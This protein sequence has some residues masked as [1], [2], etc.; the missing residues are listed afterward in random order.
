M[1]LKTKF[2]REQ[3]KLR[4]A[5]LDYVDS[6]DAL[7]LDPEFGRYGVPFGDLVGMLSYLMHQVPETIAGNQLQ[8]YQFVKS[9]EHLGIEGI[10][11]QGRQ[12]H[13]LENMPNVK[14]CSKCHVKKIIDKGENRIELCECPTFNQ[15]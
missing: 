7:H 14:T 4:K 15:R 2:E 3:K 5:W 10:R 9:D 12:Y 6:A 11:F 13:L 1:Y 8:Y